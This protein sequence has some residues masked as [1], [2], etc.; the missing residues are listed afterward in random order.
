MGL[1]AR[2]ADATGA[3][4]ESIAGG[5]L[6]VPVEAHRLAG[7]RKE[8]AGA[9]ADTAEQAPLHGRTA[10]SA[11]RPGIEPADEA[12]EHR[13]LHGAGGEQGSGDLG[14]RRRRRYSSDALQDGSGAAEDAR[15]HKAASREGRQ[16]G[17]YSTL[18]MPPPP[19]TSRGVPPLPSAIVLGI[20]SS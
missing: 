4:A 20:D 18:Y 5:A 10:A 12:A 14:A 1:G 11:S 3:A 15:H 2:V 7:R 19:C 17:P 16:R 9:S 13:C 8:A 6:G